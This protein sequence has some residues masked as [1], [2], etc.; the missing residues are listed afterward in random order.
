M[1]NAVIKGMGFEE[2]VVEMLN[3]SGLE[4]WR[5]NKANQADPVNV[6]AGFDGGVDIIAKFNHKGRTY[7]E[8]TFYIQCKNHKEPLTKSAISEAYA[9]MHA[10]GGYSDQSVPVV[11]STSDASEETIQYA[12]MLEVELIL[13]ADIELITQAKRTKKVPYG[14]YGT[15]MKAI[16][17]YFTKDSIWFDTLPDNKSNLSITSMTEQYL[18]A[19]K[20]DFDTAQAHLNSAMLLERR[21]QESRQKALDI[22]KVAVAR[23]I[24]AYG[25]YKE[26]ASKKKAQ[27][28]DLDS[29]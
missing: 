21:A 6:K 4:A 18:E 20:V 7:K 1:K 12:H 9:G 5:T 10:R 8:Y 17:F 16:M 24:Q 22:Q 2:Q 13:P 14:N 23:S 19:S 25:H 3:Q 28:N 11:F 26:K 29:G 15:L 27:A